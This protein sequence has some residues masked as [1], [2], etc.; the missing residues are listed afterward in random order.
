[1]CAVCSQMCT[2]PPLYHSDTEKN[3]KTWRFS[4][5]F[6]M[7]HEDVWVDL[8]RFILIKTYWASWF[9]PLTLLLSQQIQYFWRNYWGW[10]NN[11]CTSLFFSS[12]ERQPEVYGDLC[13]RYEDS[14]R[15][16]SKHPHYT[17]TQRSHCR[18]RLTHTKKKVNAYCIASA[19]SRPRIA[20]VQWGQTIT[21]THTHF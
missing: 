18:P 12:H 9:I 20:Q 10:A 17:R 5:E 13:S 3:L 8:W 2:Q 6:W 15:C 16:G 21:H 7:E 14:F 1:M 19:A 11:I 4:K